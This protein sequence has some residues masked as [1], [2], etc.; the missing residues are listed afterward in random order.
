MKDEKNRLASKFSHIQIRSID[1]DA[2]DRTV[3]HSQIIRQKPFLRKIYADWYATISGYLPEHH[4]GAVIELGSGGGFCKDIIPGAITTEILP[5]P[6]VDV[7][8]D[9]KALPFKDRSLKGVVM[10]DVFHHLPRVD[11]FLNEAARCVQP[12]GVVAMIEPWN[13]LWSRMV[14]RYLHHEPFDPDSSTWEIPSGGPLSQSNSALPW[15]VFERD[16][17]HFER[18]FPQWRIKDLRLHTPFRYLL[19]GGVSI[20]GSMPERLYR[21]WH[22][23]EDRLN[24]VIQYL[25]MFATIVLVRSDREKS[26]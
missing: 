13:T 5:I 18:V 3:L 15:I 8:L 24:P 26:S 23:V 11:R 16:L 25:A 10:V 21:F 7:L 12:G 17:C 4:S 6:G 14:Y 2:P 1:I 20:R 22:N 9:G 19:S